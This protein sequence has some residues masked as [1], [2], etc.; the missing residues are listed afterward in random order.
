M[1]DTRTVAKAGWLDDKA[2][3]FAT[4]RADDRFRG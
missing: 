3:K 2:G 1:I 4:V